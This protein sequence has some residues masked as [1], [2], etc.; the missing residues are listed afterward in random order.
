MKGD[1]ECAG[2]TQTRQG[3][4]LPSAGTLALAGLLC[5]TIVVGAVFGVYMMQQVDNIK[6]RVLIILE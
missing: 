4:Q 3:R 1:E 5:T 6:V 2:H